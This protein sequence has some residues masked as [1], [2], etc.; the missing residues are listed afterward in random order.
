M[1]SPRTAG[2]EHCTDQ[3]R[4]TQRECKRED[5]RAY[6]FK[7]HTRLYD[8]DAEWRLVIGG[9]D[10][11]AENMKMEIRT[12]TSYECIRRGETPKDGVGIEKGRFANGN[13]NYFDDRDKNFAPRWDGGDW[14]EL[15]LGAW[16]L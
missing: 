9:K 11:A 15:P 7:K 16:Q 14:E 8:A 3:T 12:A 5:V 13:L 2:G 10:W 1:E 6:W 4:E